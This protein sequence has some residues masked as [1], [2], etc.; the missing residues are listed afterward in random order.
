MEVAVVEFLKPYNELEEIRI[1]LGLYEILFKYRDKQTD[2]DF[3]LDLLVKGF[4]E[5]VS[6]NLNSLHGV[7]INGYPYP[8]SS[9]AEGIRI[10]QDM[11]IDNII[12]CEE[13]ALK[14]SEKTIA[15]QDVQKIRKAWLLYLALELTNSDSMSYKK[16][17][18][19]GVCEEIKHWVNS[20]AVTRCRDRESL[21]RQLFRNIGIGNSNKHEGQEPK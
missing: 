19:L 15:W 6:N 18:E 13:R 8:P 3:I 20:F 5:S 11:V 4:K 2:G 1:C 17:K 7:F 16:S 21:V 9:E 14:Y 12:N 10:F